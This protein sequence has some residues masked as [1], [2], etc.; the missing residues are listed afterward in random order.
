MQER[1]REGDE[2]GH[3][4]TYIRTYVFCFSQSFSYTPTLIFSVFLRISK[5]V[6]A[7][8]F[9]G[10]CDIRK[11]SHVREIRSA[12][13]PPLQRLSCHHLIGGSRSRRR[14]GCAIEIHP[15]KYEKGFTAITECGKFAG[16]IL[17]SCRPPVQL[18]LSRV[19]FWWQEFWVHVDAKA[20]VLRHQ[21][22]CKTEWLV[23]LC[24]VKNTYSDFSRKTFVALAQYVC[25][26]SKA[27]GDSKVWSE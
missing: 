4:I 12:L 8:H 15:G 11:R 14:P 5:S 27:V 21:L 16:N 20:V 19:N 18:I 17:L 25:V 23:L 10:P 26:A 22:S 24:L 9:P 2:Y 1:E 7:K 6:G 13:S 3:N